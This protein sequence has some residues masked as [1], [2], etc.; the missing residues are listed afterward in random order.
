MAVIAK[1]V[2]HPSPVVLGGP[3]EGRV[4]LLRGDL[5]GDAPV[6]Y[7]VSESHVPNV[8]K[9]RTGEVVDDPL[10]ITYP[11]VAHEGE[12]PR[13]DGE[14]G[15][16]DATRVEVSVRLNRGEING[17][18]A[19]GGAHLYEGHLEKKRRNILRISYYHFTPPL[20]SLSHYIRVKLE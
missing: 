12:Y 4:E 6:L 17:G 9:V 11:H 3:L 15:P 1:E 5:K 19:I 16:D 10:R 2:I 18:K 14:R 20:T 8:D 13:D 7:R